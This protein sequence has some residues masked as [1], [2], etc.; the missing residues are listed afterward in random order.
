MRSFIKISNLHFRD[1]LDV[2]TSD[3]AAFRAIEAASSSSAHVAALSR[4][5]FNV[6]LSKGATGTTGPPPRRST[7]LDAALREKRPITRDDTITTTTK[8][9][10]R[11]TQGRVESKRHSCDATQ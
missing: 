8:A 6:A 9:G 3:T 5:P 1:N 2:T 7:P 4:L 11:L 10:A